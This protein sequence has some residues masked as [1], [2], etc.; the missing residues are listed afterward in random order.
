MS[1]FRF[2][3]QGLLRLRQSQRDAAR[4]ELAEL[5]RDDALL[6][7]DLARLDAVAAAARDECRAAV[8]GTID[9]TARRDLHEYEAGIR[10]WR[11]AAMA[12]RLALESQLDRCRAA[13][14]VAQR[15]LRLVEQLADRELAEHRAQSARRA[16]REA[17]ELFAARRSPASGSRF[18][19]TD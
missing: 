14:A 15:D 6:A 11:Q 7:A 18:G 5:L 12:R 3:L 13:L 19:S 4:L 8:S 9:L 2:R 16:E 1:T 10:T 17:D